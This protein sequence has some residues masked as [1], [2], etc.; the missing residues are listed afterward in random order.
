MQNAGDEA[1]GV[2]VAAGTVCPG[3]CPALCGHRAEHTAGSEWQSLGTGAE[4]RRGLWGGS[5]ETVGWLEQ[6]PLL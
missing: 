2:K 6:S 5:P 4:D 3:W 1:C